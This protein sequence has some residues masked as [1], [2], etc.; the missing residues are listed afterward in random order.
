MS[1]MVPYNRNKLALKIAKSAR[2]EKKRADREA[3]RQEML[4]RRSAPTPIRFGHD[5]GP[6]TTPIRK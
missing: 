1:K 2:E 3:K 4:A 5:G 6:D